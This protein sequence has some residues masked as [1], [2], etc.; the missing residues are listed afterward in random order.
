MTKSKVCIVPTIRKKKMI[1]KSYKK[2]L[3]GKR[4]LVNR[5]RFILQFSL[6]NGKQLRSIQFAA[7]RFITKSLINLNL[8]G[9]VGKRFQNDERH[10][11]PSIDNRGE[12]YTEKN[13]EKKQENPAHAAS[14]KNVLLR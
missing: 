10:D 7:D 12:K 14:Q 3:S 9:D 4:G 13:A 2:F 11:E 6:E 8:V 1:S 5:L